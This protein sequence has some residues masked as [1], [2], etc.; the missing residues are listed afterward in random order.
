[1]GPGTSPSRMILFSDT[2]VRHRNRRKKRNGVRVGGRSVDSLSPAIS[3]I[4]PRYITAIRFADVLHN[5]QVMG[6]DD[7]G[8]F[9]FLLNILQEV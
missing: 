7:I 1:M 6:N 5:G 8:E 2:G 3:T 4:L 9:E